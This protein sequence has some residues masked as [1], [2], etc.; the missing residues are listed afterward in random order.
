[1]SNSFNEQK[2]Y[3]TLTLMMWLC[4]CVIFVIAVFGFFSN[5]YESKQMNIEQKRIQSDIVCGRKIK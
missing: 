1:M 5:I 3:R 4:G 2:F